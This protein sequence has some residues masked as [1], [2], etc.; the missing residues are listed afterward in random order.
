MNY[1]L[2]SNKC[3]KSVRTDRRVLCAPVQVEEAPAA[4]VDEHRGSRQPG[5]ER[6]ANAIDIMYKLEL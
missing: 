4:P 5:E 1:F 6:G 2:K 3:V